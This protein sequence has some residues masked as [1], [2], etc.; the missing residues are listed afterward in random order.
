MYKMKSRGPKT[1]LCATPKL[2]LSRLDGITSI[3][4]LMRVFLM[5]L[6]CLG[7]L[8]DHRQNEKERKI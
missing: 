5:A 8:K 6:C 7:C 1:D 3:A 4:T 2:T